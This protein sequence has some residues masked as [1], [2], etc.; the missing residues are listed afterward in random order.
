MMAGHSFTFLGTISGNSNSVEL[1]LQIG[2]VGISHI[3]KQDIYFC[4][5]QQ[6]RP[7]SL[8]VFSRA[9]GLDEDMQEISC[10]F[11][12]LLPLILSNMLPVFLIY[13]VYCMFLPTPQ[14]CKL[15][16]S[17]VLSFC[18]FQFVF[19]FSPAIHPDSE[20]CLVHIRHALIIICLFT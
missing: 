8:W 7:D 20:H 10:I 18:F 1:I 11:F 19:F 9:D 2:V 12:S 13:L 16:E 15:H 3:V 14:F 4:L 5:R 6:T 17:E